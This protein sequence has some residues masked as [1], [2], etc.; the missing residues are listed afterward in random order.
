MHRRQRVGEGHRPLGAARAPAE[1]GA[2]DEVHDARRPVPR[3]ADVPLHVR[4]VGEQLAVRV[5]GQV[6]GVAHAAGDHLPPRGVGVGAQHHRAGRAVAD[7]V[8]ARVPDARQ[9]DVLAPVAVRRVG[10]DPLGQAGR[11]AVDHVEHA[12]GAEH[13]AVRAVLARRAVARQVVVLL[14]DAV[15]VGVAQAV[16]AAGARLAARHVGVQRAV[17]EQQALRRTHR[18]VEHLDLRRGVVALREAEAD[19]RAALGRDVDLALGAEGHAGP[20]ALGGAC[21]V[22]QLGAEALGQ[23]EALDRRGDARR[24]GLPPRA[25]VRADR[26]EAVHRGP[27]RGAEGVAPHGGPAGRLDGGGAPALAGDQRAAR[28]VRPLELDHRGQRGGAVEVPGLDRQPVQAGGQLAPRR[29][30]ARPL[31]V[32]AGGQ[33]LAVEVH[34]EGVVAR[35]LAAG[36]AGRR[37]ELEA[38]QEPAALAGLGGGGAPHPLGAAHHRRR[39]GDAREGLEA[40]LLRAGDPAH[41]HAAVAHLHR[42][43]L[44]Q[45]HGEAAAAAPRG[46]LLVPHVDH[47]HAVDLVH[48]ARADRD[49]AV[50][51]PLTRAHRALQRGPVAEGLALAALAVGA[52]PQPRAARGEDRAPVALVEDPGVVRPVLDVGLV[53][54][55][56]AARELFA[57]VLHARV[58]AGD[59]VLEAQ[60][61]VVR[62]EVGEQV[63][64]ARQRLGG[65]AD[66]AAVLHAPVRGVAV[67]AGEVDAVEQRG[68]RVRHAGAGRGQGEEQEPP[69]LHGRHPRRTARALSPARARRGSRPR[70]PAARRAACW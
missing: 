14:E 34:A 17:G 57:A 39:R 16:Q 26:A 22:D 36:D 58:A 11:V 9:Q 37:V 68:L 27:R 40:G 65:A 41:H 62:L 51:V 13:D 25:G 18:R 8:A 4:V 19:E 12:V 21:R 2:G 50:L 38:V 1:L 46:G 54:G 24:Q 66:Q 52:D 33:R 64:R 56:V 59:A 49:H 6:V 45:L 43:T 53:A 30:R 15:P 44:V 32:L 28:A 31:P 35:H 47:A 23:D 55:H 61:E 20:R 60:L 63:G 10:G 67:P 69:V 3:R 70:A 7:G 42:R 5:E 48:E 29:H